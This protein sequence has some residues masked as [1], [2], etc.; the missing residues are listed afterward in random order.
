MLKMVSATPHL[1]G[2]VAVCSG[3]PKAMKAEEISTLANGGGGGGPA[4]T[5]A[6]TMEEA[7]TQAAA[8]L[9]QAAAAADPPPQKQMGTVLCFGCFRR[10]RDARGARQTRARALSTRT[11]GC[12]RGAK[13]PPLVM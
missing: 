7:L 11:T 2:A 13:E 10:R 1:V 4:W 9:R 6:A 12:S 8:A 3:H 5:A